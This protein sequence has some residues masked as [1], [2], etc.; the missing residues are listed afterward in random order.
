MLKQ[1]LEN[2]HKHVSFESFS[3]LRNGYTNRKFKQKTLE[4]LFIEELCLL[5]NTQELSVPSL[6][7]NDLTS[8]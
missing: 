7:Y 3:V 6:L 5:L 1:S 2:N 4:A 8:G